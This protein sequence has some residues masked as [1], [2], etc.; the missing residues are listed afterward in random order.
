ML[1]TEIVGNPP[2][3]YGK[4]IIIER[5]GNFLSYV[6]LSRPAPQICRYVCSTSGS[7]LLLNMYLPLRKDLSYTDL[8]KLV[9]VHQKDLNDDTLVIIRCLFSARLIARYRSSVM[10]NSLSV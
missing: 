8:L 6:E 4:L 9:I 7:M 10:A 1:A 5:K 2:E 3:I